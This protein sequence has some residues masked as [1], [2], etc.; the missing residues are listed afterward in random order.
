MLHPG[1]PIMAWFIGVCDVRSVLWIRTVGA[2]VDVRAVG[3]WRALPWTEGSVMLGS[4]WP[5]TAGAVTLAGHCQLSFLKWQPSRTCCWLRT[6]T[7]MW[8]CE[9]CDILVPRTDKKKHYSP[10]WER[11]LFWTQSL[12]IYVSAGWETA[13]HWHLESNFLFFFRE[14]LSSKLQRW[15]NDASTEVAEAAG[16]L[17]A[18]PRASKSPRAP[19][20]NAAKSAA[21]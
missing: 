9:A 11:F 13:T 4:R 17:K 21:E 10:S 2:S 5:G 16:P 7:K 12:I 19:H 14:N 18:S 6:P 15:T 20:I 3:F 1:C 8:V